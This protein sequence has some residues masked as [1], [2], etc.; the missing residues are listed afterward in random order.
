MRHRTPLAL[1]ATAALMLTLAGCRRPQGPDGTY[2]AF[3]AA[4]RAGD[5]G[6]V[7]GLLSE[8]SRAALDARAKAL[9]AR[10]PGTPA[11][12]R[13]LALGDLAAGAP[14]IA[15]V[16]V[17]SESA[18]AAVLGVTVEGSDAREEVHMAREGGSW[19][20]VLPEVRA[21]TP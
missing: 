7:Y 16:E 15:R 18:D 10:V 6:Q 2:R 5:A 8:R 4:A 21:A 11:S 1:L 19:R 3:A 12:G 20:V 13:E 17:L 9:A 14:R